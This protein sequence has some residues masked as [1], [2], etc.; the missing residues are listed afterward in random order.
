MY[1]PSVLFSFLEV[2]LKRRPRA[3]E[4]EVKQLMSAQLK[5]HLAVCMMGVEQW[6]RK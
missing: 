6:L 3:I 1:I 4:A 2:A 5:T